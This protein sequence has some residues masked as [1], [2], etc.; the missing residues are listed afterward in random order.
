M[1]TTMESMTTKV[2]SETGAEME[3]LDFVILSLYFLFVLAVGMAVSTLPRFISSVLCFVW[4]LSSRYSLEMLSSAIEMNG[5]LLSPGT[6]P[7]NVMLNFHSLILD[8][9]HQGV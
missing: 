2:P 8:I 5:H 3:P 9:S 6:A 7:A 4:N 1:A